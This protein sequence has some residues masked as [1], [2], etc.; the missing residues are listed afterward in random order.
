[1]FLAES[2]ELLEALH[3]ELLL[4]AVVD[5]MQVNPHGIEAELPGGCRQLALDDL[6]TEV[7][8]H[9]HLVSGVGRSVIG[10][11]PGRSVVGLRRSG[12][13]RRG[14]L[15]HRR[16]EQRRAWQQYPKDRL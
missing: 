10:P 15:D 14:A 3:E 1:M 13:G 16:H 7:V 12:G 9:L 8:P 5:V 2:Q 6:G 4:L 11:D